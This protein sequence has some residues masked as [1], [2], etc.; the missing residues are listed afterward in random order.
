[1]TSCIMLT[2]RIVTMFK[3]E[4]MATDK[5]S[6]RIFYFSWSKSHMTKF[7]NSVNALIRFGQHIF[8]SQDH[9]KK[10]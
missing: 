3:K 10:T 6:L 9:E 7:L 8:E 2:T 1:M 5:L 4:S